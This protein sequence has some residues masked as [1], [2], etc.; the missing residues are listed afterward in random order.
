MSIDLTSN[1][2]ILAFL[3]GYLAGAIPFGLLLTKAFRAGGYPPAGFGQ[4]WRD[5]CFAHRQSL[6]G[7]SHLVCRY[8]QGHIARPHW[9]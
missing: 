6:A 2:L 3:F 9:R 1:F 5:Q 4:Y 7:R 8:A